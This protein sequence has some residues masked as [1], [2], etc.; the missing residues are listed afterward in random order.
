MKRKNLR[1]QLCVPVERTAIAQPIKNNYLASNGAIAPSQGQWSWL[2]NVARGSTTEAVNYLYPRYTQCRCENIWP[3]GE[4]H[5]RASEG[6]T[7][8]YAT[9]C[10]CW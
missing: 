7:Y 4:A 6:Y 5:P 3:T 8:Q 1:P 9:T 2:G 10:T